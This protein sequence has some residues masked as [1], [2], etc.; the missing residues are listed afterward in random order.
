MTT[1]FT[2][3]AISSALLW[4][5]TNRF[6][7]LTLSFVSIQTFVFLSIPVVALLNRPLF[8]SIMVVVYRCALFW[9]IVYAVSPRD[10]GYLIHYASHQLYQFLAPTPTDVYYTV[11]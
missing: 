10:V 11:I 7:A 3:F 8:D 9:S 4:G 6:D 1:L 2:P 5:N